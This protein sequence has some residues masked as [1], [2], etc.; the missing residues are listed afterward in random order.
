MDRRRSA[1]AAGIL[2]VEKAVFIIVISCTFSWIVMIVRAT[3]GQLYGHLHGL[4]IMVTAFSFV[5][6]SCENV[7]KSFVQKML[8]ST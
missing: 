1:A 7:S 5:S 6:V 2:M 8:N 4:H 3:S